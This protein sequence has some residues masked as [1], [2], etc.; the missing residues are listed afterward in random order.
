MAAGLKDKS[1]KVRKQTL[2]LL[3]QLTQEDFLRLRGSLFFTL[4][5]MI[6][7]KSNDIAEMARFFFADRLIP[8]NPQIMFQNL[9]AALSFYND[10]KVN[11]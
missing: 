8:K 3:V 4:L 2:I 5:A 10:L 9:I 1:Q 11:F 6:R 7:D